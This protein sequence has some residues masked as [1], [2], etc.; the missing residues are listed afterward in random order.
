MSYPVWPAVLPQT[1]RR[2]SWAG[3]AQESRA[4]FEPEYGPPVSRRRVTADPQIYTGVVWP[5]CSDAGRAAFE[6]F[7]AQ[8]LAGGAMPFLMRDPVAGDWARWKILRGGQTPYTFT[9]KGA[10]LHDLSMSLMRLPGATWF[11]P[12]IPAGTSDVPALVLDFAAGVYGIDGARKA[13]A[14]IVQFTRP[15][16]AAY[17]DAT[18]TVRVAAVDVPRFDHDATTFAPLGLL[19]DDSFSE[20]ANILPASWPEGLFAGTGSMLVALRSQQTTSPT[21]R[22]VF[23]ARGATFA[24]TL[25]VVCDATRVAFQATVATVSQANIGLGAYT[26]DTRV[27]VAA[28]FAPNDFRASRAGGAAVADTSGTMPVVDRAALGYA[29][30]RVWIERVVAWRRSLPNSV[31]Q[32]LSA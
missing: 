28:A 25:A 8:D 1:P 2:Q 12:Y 22:A 19:M 11:A 4:L 23:A 32:A 21:Y 7:W 29:E 9:S 10:G 15:G 14:D 6:A 18:G 16:T 24:D 27:A 30:D 13:F 20:S 26:V 5:N 17:R 3:G 31:L